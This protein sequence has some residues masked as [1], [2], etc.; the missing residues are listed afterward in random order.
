MH[1]LYRISSVIYRLI[2]TLTIP[3]LLLFKILVAAAGHNRDFERKDYLFFAYI[4][5]TVILLT[6][7]HN[8]NKRNTTNKIVLFYPATGLVLTSIV[9]EVL[10][11][12]DTFFICKCFTSSDNIGSV[13][14][15]LFLLIPIIVFVGL[16]NEQKNI[17][18]KV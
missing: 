4:L 6:L 15:F 17:E 10:S 3:V 9:L 13:L 12:Y 14:T 16:I 11:L 1:R 2:L 18:K 8:S 5:A 7:H